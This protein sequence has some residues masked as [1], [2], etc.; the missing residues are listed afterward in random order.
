MT[1]D[2]KVAVVTGA[3]RGIGREAA[4]ILGEKG[5]KVVI[6]DLDR[7]AMAEDLANQLG[8]D[9]ALVLSADVTDS[10]QARALVDRAVA[11]F[12]TIDILVNNVGGSLGTPRFV[13]QLSDADWHRVIDLCLSSQF[14]MTR[15]AA[16]IMKAQRW[17]RII[18]ISSTAG[19]YGDPQIWSPAY[20]AAK[21]GVTG[22]TRQV[23]IELGRHN[24]TVNAVAPG[25][26]VTERLREIWAT[27]WP[28]SEEQ[29]KQ[30]WEATIPLQR[31]ATPVEVA[32]VIVFLASDEA[33]FI[34]GATIDVNGGE[35][36]R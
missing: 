10:A 11:S 36:M 23:A 16:P 18:N 29:R 13:E 14:Y 12:G 7:I 20:A 1:V 24:I 4:R 2:G 17:G 26:T 28:E 9:R 35:R 30:R 25:G 32:N 15:A 34:N 33:G 22:F 3:G 19:V 31:P 6:C 21:A 8:N 27:N 5:A